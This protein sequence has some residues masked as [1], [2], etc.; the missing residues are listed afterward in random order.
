MNHYLL[1]MKILD[2][3][4]N[5]YTIEII[6]DKQSTNIYFSPITKDLRYTE[7]D[8]LTSFLKLKEFQLRKI[9]HNKQP[10]TFYK[11][12]KLTFVLQDVLPDPNYY[13]R[14]KVTVLDNTNNEYLVKKTDKKSEKIIEAYTD[15]SFLLEKNSGG[16]A[17]L[18]KYVS[19]ETQLYSYKTSKK[20]SNLIELNA[21]IKS[22]ELL[23]EET[24]ICINTDSQYVIKGITEW[25]PIWILN[26]WHTANG[27]KA[28]NSK[29]WKKIIKLVKNKYIEFVWIKAHTNQYENTICDL[30]AKQ[31][32]KN[33][34]K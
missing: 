9:L 31:T 8:S 26:N 15:G 25:I 34:S 19:G 14:T 23:K 6:L 2:V 12:F 18:I 32:A 16:F 28:K 11:G 29:D 7:R 22:L 24:K 20:G 27:T 4:D 17:V 33:N 21:V 30:T 1:D 5:C 13:D 10:D 3:V